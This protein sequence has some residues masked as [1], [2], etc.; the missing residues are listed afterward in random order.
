MLYLL[1]VEI[2]TLDGGSLVTHFTVEWDISS[3][4]NSN[5]D[6]SKGPLGQTNVP[7]YEVLCAACVS[8]IELPSALNQYT[9]IVS[10]NGTAI[11][12]QLLQVGRRV[13][14]VTTDDNIPYLFT[15]SD[16]QATASSF[17]VAS[18]SLRNS[19]FNGSATG[20]ADLLLLGAQFPIP[21]LSTGSQYFFRV[22]AVNSIG[23]CPAFLAGCGAFI[24][25]APPSLVVAGPPSAPAN[26]VAQV[27]NAQAVSISWTRPEDVGSFVSAYRVDAYTMSSQATADFSFF[28]D[29]EVQALSTAS[30][31]VTGGTFTV[32]F[33]SFSILLPAN[34]SARIDS[35]FFST[36][37]D[38]TPYLD[39]GDQVLIDGV[40]YTIDSHAMSNNTGFFVT[41]IIKSPNL[42]NLALLPLYARPRTVPLDFDV[43]AVLLR[44][45]LQSTTGFGQ[46][47]VDRTV[48]GNG[49]EWMVTFLTNSGRQP[50]LIANSGNLIGPNPDITVIEL[51]QG[52]LPNNFKSQIFG[53]TADT[54]NVTVSG[55]FVGVPWYLRVLA[56]NQVGVG[57]FSEPVS[58]VPASA[59]GSPSFLTIQ[60]ASG[61]SILAIFAQDADP[62]GSP[63][64]GYRLSI[65]SSASLLPGSTVGR[66]L[67]ASNSTVF[68][69]VNYTFQRVTTSAFAL[70]FSPGATFRLSVA[71]FLGAFNTYLGKTESRP[72]SFDAIDGTSFVNRSAT[73]P[74]VFHPH[75]EVTPGE[76][77]S[78]ASQTF[79][80]CLNQDP[81]FV[82]TYGSLTASM[83]PLCSVTDPYSAAFIYTGYS[84]K[85]LSNT[86]VYRLDTYV[87]GVNNPQLGSS[88]I[89][90]EFYD[91][92]L[93]TASAST[94]SVGDWIRYFSNIYHNQVLIDIS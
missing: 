52:T 4:F 26:L 45:V 11:D 8:F 32:A 16:G 87:G 1:K 20:L 89:V 48:V 57:P 51:R 42:K 61:S 44:S 67:D 71:S 79:R 62:M 27:I 9:T 59:P 83:I 15:V 2:R 80:V 5:P 58:A 55:L 41:I 66:R 21:S 53:A 65:Q 30:S 81:S 76:F 74:S 34:V 54:M 69:P 12:A 3:G 73:D 14:I 75:I 43:S 40:T 70:P 31:Y 13:A 25:T 50:L 64:T 28:G 29:A 18:S 88:S 49:F 68:L 85:V 36:T 82:G 86:P 7:A 78:V 35:Y 63:I 46:V 22:N 39:P 37:A 91:G 47:W 77:I 10:Y 19:N 33:D 72:G 24:A 6:G 60:S 38:L 90:L 92:A 23:K 93:N 17:Q 56:I 84:G 94:L